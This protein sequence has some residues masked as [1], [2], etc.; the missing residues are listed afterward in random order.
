MD[1]DVATVLYAALVLLFIAAGLV[2][3]PVVALPVT[4]PCPSPSCPTVF[5]AIGH[6]VSARLS[7]V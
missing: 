5:A 2:V 4:V 3:S 7:G 1:L 6:G